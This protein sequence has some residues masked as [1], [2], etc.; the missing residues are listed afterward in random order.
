MK[1]FFSLFIACGF[2]VATGAHAQVNRPQPS[3]S[4]TPR[5][6]VAT[7]QI[8]DCGCEDKPLPEV[9]ATVNGIRISK[10]DVS[11][12]AQQRIR[13]LQQEVIEA[14]KRELDLQINSLL[15]ETEAR[16][17]GTT[18]TRLLE[19]E[20][21]AKV[22]K[23]TDAEA[24]AFYDQNKERI[25]RDFASVKAEVVSYLIEQRQRDAAKNLADRLRAA[26]VLRI[27]NEAVTPGLTAAARARI[28]ATVNGKNITSG[29]IE[30]SLKPLIFSVQDS[31]YGFRK[32]EIELRINDALLEQEAKKRAI[33]TTSVLATEVT[34][35]VKPVSDAD[36]LAFFNA[37]KERMN[38][39][40]AQLKS[41]IIEY[42]KE[43]ALRNA[44]AD[45]AERLRN[46]AQIQIFLTPPQQPTY[47]LAVD[48]QPTRGSATASVTLIEFTDFQCP[49]CARQH[50]VL[51]RLFAEY[52]S[53]VKFVIR[54]FPLSQYENSAKAAEAAEAA[55]E[56][57]KY[58]EYVALLYRNQSALQVDRLKQYASTLGL[59]RVKFDAAMDSGKFA[60]KILRDR[61]DGQKAGVSSAPVFFVNGKRVSEPS[62]ETLKAAIETNLK[63]R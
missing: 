26:A 11:E 52:G 41:Q 25:G 61:L 20:V 63:P 36:A 58:W 31:A 28:F 9:L 22:V 43:Q 50:P 10:L 4:P 42:L 59:D 7:S 49:S 30:D 8:V 6:P 16:K 37:N 32:R 18:T 2:V 34:A 17:R 15:L 56:Q 23:P 29:D 12:A 5:A 13:E 51:D 60:E 46:A 21:V 40:F 1:M 35:K 53:R 62:Y 57:G 3:P 45:F 19:A 27:S 54:D 55:R 24:Q 44:Q 14:R 39:D 33:T 47:Q 48:D 38:G